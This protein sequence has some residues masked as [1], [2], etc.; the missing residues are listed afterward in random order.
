MEEKMIYVV[1]DTKNGNLYEKFDSYEEAFEYV[2][3]EYLY[4]KEHE[5]DEYCTFI[6]GYYGI[7]SISEDDVELY[8]WDYIDNNVEALTFLKT[9]YYKD[10]VE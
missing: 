3:E 9:I 2:K 10:V 1:G 8:G 5:N 7:Y 4:D 6:D